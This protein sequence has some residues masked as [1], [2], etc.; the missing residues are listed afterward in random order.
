MK[1]H[2]L[3][4]T[5]IFL[6]ILGP[7]AFAGIISAVILNALL[8]PVFI[9]YFT[10]KSTT[11]LKLASSL[12]F[13]RCEENF[14]DLLSQ[15]LSDN[16]MMTATMY[17][18]TLREI[19]QVHDRL[20]SV[21]LLAILR[22]GTVE[23]STYP[24]I[25][26]NS[27]FTLPDP[28]I[29]EVQEF[30][31]DGRALLYHSRD[32]PFG[33][34]HVVALVPLE[35]ISAPVRMIE[36]GLIFSLIG[37]SIVLLV[38]LL[39]TVQFAIKRPLNRIIEATK[40][41]SEGSFPQ[42]QSTRQDEIG[43]VTAAVN[44][45]SSHLKE[46][47]RALQNSIAEKSVLL[48]EIHHRV[49]N[50]LNVV[51]SLLHL[52]FDQAEKVEDPRQILKSSCDRIYSMALIHE[53]LYQSENFSQI[54]LQDYTE[55]IV[56]QLFSIYAQNKHIE[57]HIHVED[58]YVN[59]T[60]AMPFGLILNELIT[61]SLLHAFPNRTSG[62]IEISIRHMDADNWEFI[63]SDDGIGIDPDFDF[64]AQRA[65]LGLS[66]IYILG[67]QIGALLDLQNRNG[68]WLRLVIPNLKSPQ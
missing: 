57:K 4:P 31:K 21:H 17:Q 5:T 19:T 15:R 61:N 66:L 18:E 36:G 39:I 32:V 30:K 12:A 59:L 41:I 63:Y 33:R 40:Q 62:R 50:N 53:K 68:Y 51:V 65:S 67:R 25:P 22:K 16:E 46:N 11:D 13:E 23:A 54:D 26:V 2:R 58:F 20:P 37:I 47:H 7:V 49:K 42:I 34:L 60:V 52:Q 48:Q 28:G 27:N 35:A 43:K 8:T 44:D 45:M 6:Y 14:H 9:D 1:L 10:E 24:A 56:D 3:F 64:T 38:T 29:S 55:T